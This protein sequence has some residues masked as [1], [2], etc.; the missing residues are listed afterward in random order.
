M[1]LNRVSTN[2]VMKHLPIHNQQTAFRCQYVLTKFILAVLLVFIVS[3]TKANENNQ[4]L[5]SAN[6]EYAKGN[7]ENAIGLYESIIN[8]GEVAPELYFNL[9]NAYYKTNKIGYAI[10]YYERAK[11]LD[12]NDGD[13]ATNLKLANQRTE[14]KIEAAPIL[15]LT[16]WLDT[17]VQLMTEKGWSTVCI[18]SFIMALVLLGL[19]ILT[20]NSIL[21]KI[22]FFGGILLIFTGIFL[23]FIAK[24]KYNLS[25]YGG[26]AII[27]SVSV[28]ANS[29]PNEKG[30]K[31]FVLH[32]GTKVSITQED[33]SWTEI[34]IANGDVGWVKSKSLTAI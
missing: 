26:E 5:D 23:F 1:K 2:N 14:D 17:L 20:T 15:F 7:Y 16:E 24:H 4:T 9:G 13:I 11:K 33:E 3:Y 34:K 10:L 8:K 27:T 6:S 25:K 32:E 28:T 22:G 31:L 19:Y 29:S 18:L 12:P 21:K 30:T